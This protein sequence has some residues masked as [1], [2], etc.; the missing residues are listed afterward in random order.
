MTIV[1]K[2]KKA[3]S[4]YK[5]QVIWTIEENNLDQQYVSNLNME[6]KT[7]THT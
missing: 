5:Q 7:S 3:V 6:E 1:L 2:I 4:T